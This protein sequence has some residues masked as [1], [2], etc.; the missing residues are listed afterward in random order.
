MSNLALH[1]SEPVRKEPYPAWPVHDERDIEAVTAVIKSG[2]WGGYPY[3]GPQTAEFTR[4]F[5]DMQGGGYAVAVANGT[6]TMEVALRAAGIGWGDEVIVPAYTFQAT[7]TA[8]MAAGAIP[9]IVDIDPE[10]Y[11]IDPKAVEAAITPKT[12]AVI[13]VHLGAQMADMDA[14]MDIAERHNLIVI[15]D[16]AHAHGAKWRGRGAGT[17]GHFGSFSLQSSKILST[18]EG[19]VLLCRTPELA[20]RV[21][22]IIDCGRPHDEAEQMFTMGANF[23]MP[24]IQAALGN[25][26]IERFPEQARQREAMGDYMDEALSDIPGVRI[27]KRDPR[28]TT[29]SFYRY[30]FAVNP[31]VFGAEHK[32]VCAALAAEGIPCWEGYEAMHHYELF[33]PHLSKLPV[34][35]AFPERFQFETMHLPQAER[36]C[37]HE[38]VWLDEAIF[39]AGPR[40]VDDAVAAIRK[41]QAHAAE[42]RNPA[43]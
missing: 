23:R 19:G 38:A 7:A 6:I 1:G 9:V 4:R 17:I 8:P 14:L 36:A 33:Q 41:I 29:R 27:L 26:A 5:A 24:E 21:A 35:S 32:L 11:C 22:S 37:E 12:K 43:R 3:P 30:I 2:R 20:T 10:T 31:A 16:C 34:P 25:V 13:P 42:L 28:H 40:G 18:G 15:E 39:R